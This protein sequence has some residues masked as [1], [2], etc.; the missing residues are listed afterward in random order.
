MSLNVK[1]FLLVLAP[2]GLLLGINAL[3]IRHSS[4]IYEQAIRE[5]TD[6]QALAVQH[7]IQNL[8]QEMDFSARALASSRE[9]AQAVATMDNHLLF[10]WSSQLLGRSDTVAV[11]NLDG[12]VVSRAP[13]E[14]RFG[15]DLSGEEFFRLTLARGAYQDTGVLDGRLSWIAAY[16]VHK[17]DDIPLGVV[18]VAAAITPAILHSFI[19]QPGIVLEFTEGD[20]HIASAMRPEKVLRQRDIRLPQDID[21]GRASRLSLFFAEDKADQSLAELKRQM[22]TGPMLTGL[23]LFGI[24]L[25]FLRR[26]MKPYSRLVHVML[27]YASEQGDESSLR[28]G[29]QKLGGHSGHGAARIA[30]ALLQLLDKVAASTARNTQYTQELSRSVE[31]LRESEERFRVLFHQA[32][33]PLFIWR[34]NDTL[35]DANDAACRLLGYGREEL[36]RMSLAEIQAPSVRQQDGKTV[37]DELQAAPFEGIDLRKDGTEVPVEIITVPIRLQGEDYALSAVRDISERKRAEAEQEKLQ[38]QL[39]QAQ[40]MESVGILAGGVAHDFNNLLQT[41]GGNIEL[42]LQGKSEDNPD[43]RRLRNVA[44]SIDRAAQL[45]RQLLLFGR[46]AGSR[47]VRVDLNQEVQEAVHILE[48]TIPKM[49]ALELHLDPSVGPLL[50]DPVQIEQIVLNLAGN[51][52]DAMPDGGKLVLETRNKILDKDF[53]RIHPDAFAGRHVLLTVTDTGCGMGK[54]TLEHIYDPF[55][56]TKEVGKGTGLGLASVYGIVKAH[57]GHIQCSS[58]PGAGTTFKI[59]LPAAEQV[60]DSIADHRQE[61]D[62]QAGNETILVVDDEPEIRELTREALE[63]L[64]YTVH[65]ASNGEEAV[66]FYRE[67]GQDIDLVLLDLNMPGMGGHQCLRELFQI[68]PAVKVIIASGYTA[69]GHGK[70]AVNSGAKCFLGKPYQLKE[71]EAAVRGALGKD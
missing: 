14:F 28:S 45:V 41:M 38:N 35:L 32:P 36:L 55:F 22:I 65:S 8:L 42:L 53:I 21:Q 19:D 51:A 5:R 24:L 12:I 23:V 64:G 16:R 26:Q 67:H 30:H 61:T 69:D 54:E 33:D 29:L 46:K 20:Q 9:F 11:I 60:D 31:A 66:T 48:R 25:F 58:E 13:D 15:D 43:A 7:S 1:I 18:L 10:E 57:G 52:V 44:R 17:Y 34:L 6:L 37:R 39:L 63:S 47:R 40:K 68:D 49:I 50:A 71:L 70:D 27:T 62:H 59:Y 4:I 2:I 56:T 3:L